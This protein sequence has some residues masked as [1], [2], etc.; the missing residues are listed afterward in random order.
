[1]REVAARDR[2]T[3]LTLDV[4]WQS[5]TSVCVDEAREEVVLQRLRGAVRRRDELE[6]RLPVLGLAEALVLARG[7]EHAEEMNKTTSEW[8]EVFVRLASCVSGPFDDLLLPSF[9]ARADYEG[10]QQRPP[11]L[12][13]LATG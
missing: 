8:P 2:G 13:V 9:S 6:G 11:S 5:P 4:G 12:A 7:V 1:M 10:W 3:E